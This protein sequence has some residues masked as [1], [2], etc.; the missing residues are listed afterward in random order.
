MDDQSNENFTPEFDIDQPE[1]S[2]RSVLA[3]TAGLGLISRYMPEKAPNNV[4]PP[5]GKPV[6]IGSRLELFVDDYLIDEMDGVS[7]HLHSPDP[8]DV[9]IVFDEPWE[10]DGSAYI[11]VFWDDEI[12]RYRMYYRGTTIGETQYT[13]YAE[14]EEGINWEK[15]SLGIIEHEGSTDNNIVW[16]RWPDAHNMAPFKD[17]NPDADSDAK[18]KALAGTGES[19]ALKS[20]DGIHWERI[21]NTPVLTEGAF[22]SQNIAF[23]DTVREEYRAY[24][25]YFD[26]GRRAIRTARS[27]D[28]VNWEEFTDLEYP[29]APAEQLYINGINPYYRAPHIFLGFPGRYHER[30]WDSPS[31]KKLPGYEERVERTERFDLRQGAAVSD[32]L[33]MS[34]RGTDTFQRWNR[35]F[36]RPGLWEDDTVNSWTYATNWMA[37]APVETPSPVEGRP[38]EISMYAL[39]HYWHPDPQMRR[40]SIRIDGFVSMRAPLSGGE[41]VT[42]PVKFTNDK[43][44]LNYATSAAGT[45][46]VELQN[47]A[48]KPIEGFTLDDSPKIFGDD[49]DR[50]VEWQ[51][52]RK[53]SDLKDEDGEYPPVRLR[54]VMSD[55]DLYSFRFADLEETLPE[56]PENPV[57]HYSFDRTLGGEV[58]ADASGNGN[59]AT[60]NGGT[61]DSGTIDN[62]VRFDR[63]DT[64]ADTPTLTFEDEVSVAGWVNTEAVDDSHFIAMGALGAESK[65]NLYLFGDRPT[66]WLGTDDSQGYRLARNP[67]IPTGEWVHLAGTYDGNDLRLYINGSLAATQA[68]DVP[69]LLEPVPCRVGADLRDGTAGDWEFDGRIDDLQLFNRALTESEVQDHYNNATQPNNPVAY[70]PFDQLQQTQEYFEDT[71]SNGNDATNNGAVTDAGVIDN[72]IRLDQN[73][74]WADTPTLS[75]ENEVSVA[76]WVNTEDT[77]STHQIIQ[78]AI[79]EQAIVSLY[80]FG[81]QPTWW[82]AIEE[83]DWRLARNPT[84]PTGEWVHLAGTYD[85]E[86]L[87]LYIDG[88]LAATQSVPYDILQPAPARVGADLRPQYDG[89]SEFDG[90]IDDMWVFDRALDANE[91]EYLSDQMSS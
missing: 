29:D 45:I 8:Q 42:N 56:K 44:V 9:S 4:N 90:R 35:T 80:L 54:F 6:D 73:D 23:W 37:V 40:Y 83:G 63:N 47:P 84:I 79:G 61:V 26:S 5:Q 64:W 14:S 70:Y 49:L 36:H 13:C 22:D 21:Q 11:T 51:G 91:I 34:S 19:Y 58:F 76:G 28:F 10:G 81:A 16:D 82:L 88:Q 15:P 52:D 59:D 67:S 50:I 55:A 27:D 1:M 89:D 66:W 33:F 78:A 7:Q 2:R 43:L 62:A 3:G 24:F 20:P 12:E 77:G 17:P 60:N 53:L 86:T 75:F 74:T 68:V 32:T 69:D 85:G 71:S 87:R 25:R 72:A 65:F 39:E 41:F 46:K 18:Y 57:A 38:N 31:M 48:G 30:D